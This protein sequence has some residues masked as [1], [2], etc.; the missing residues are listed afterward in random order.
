MRAFQ[1][2][3]VAWPN[4]VEEVNRLPVIMMVQDPLREN[5][6]DK[7]RTPTRWGADGAEAAIQTLMA[8][9]PIFSFPCAF[10][11]QEGHLA[12]PS[13]SFRD[14]TFREHRTTRVPSTLLRAR[15]AQE[16]DQAFPHSSC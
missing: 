8:P 12:A 13:S 10:C 1:K 2:C 5:R 7:R 4:L 16:T 11:A 3:A 6:K 15:R 9:D 14:R